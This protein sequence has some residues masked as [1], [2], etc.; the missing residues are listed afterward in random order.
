MSNHKTVYRD[1]NRCIKVFGPGCTG[2]RVLFEAYAQSLA[3]KAGLPAPAVLKVCRVE[4]N[5]AMVSRFIKGQSLARLLHRQ[6]ENA[7]QLLQGI[8]TVSN[9]ILAQSGLE[10]PSLHARLLQSLASSGLPAKQIKAFRAQIDA[11][12]QEQA[13]CHGCLTPEN[14]IVTPNGQLYA[15]SWALAG[16]GC[17]Q[18][19]AAETCLWL[20]KDFNAALAKQYLSLFC[21]Q[22]GLETQQ[23][24]RL[25][26]AVAAARLCTATPTSR[27][28]LTDFLKNFEG[29]CPL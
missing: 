1:S 13:F 25:L 22:N 26:P 14:L 4:E 28:F 19:E 21:S 5:W 7:L 27:D 12:P 18:V 15:L 23:I 6:P 29:E 17:R 24:A 11:L 2:D 10:L 8:A 9:Q 20:L 3:A 16:A